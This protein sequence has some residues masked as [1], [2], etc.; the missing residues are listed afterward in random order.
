MRSLG[1]I[2]IYRKDYI[3]IIILQVEIDEYQNYEKALGAL[4]EAY[5][6]DQIIFKT[7][8]IPFLPKSMSNPYTHVL[9]LLALGK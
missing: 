3:I 2:R 6:Y 5:R 8:L 7:Q 4:S 9:N 1:G